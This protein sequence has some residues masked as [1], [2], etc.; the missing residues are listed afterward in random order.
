MT[1]LSIDV[2]NNRYVGTDVQKKKNNNIFE[3]NISVLSV[4]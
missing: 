2:N 4:Q 3:I 1:Y